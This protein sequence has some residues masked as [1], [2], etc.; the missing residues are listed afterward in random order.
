[1]KRI[2]AWFA[3]LVNLQEN[4]PTI[5]LK[6]QSNPFLSAPQR[7][8]RLL[9]RLYLPAIFC[10]SVLIVTFDKLIKN[11][12]KTRMCYKYRLIT[13]TKLLARQHSL[14]WIESLLDLKNFKLNNRSRKSIRRFRKRRYRRRIIKGLWKHFMGNCRIKR[15]REE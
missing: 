1:M 7:D 15:I 11:D 13:Y 2:S 3:G 12:Y 9:C 10:S 8:V 14:D 5:V 6:D 4:L